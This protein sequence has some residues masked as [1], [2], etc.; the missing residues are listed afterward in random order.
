LGDANGD[1][2]RVCFK[3]FIAIYVGLL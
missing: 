3:S 2:L 1:A